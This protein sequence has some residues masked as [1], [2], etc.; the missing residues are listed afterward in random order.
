MNIFQQIEQMD[1][2]L[3]D[4]APML[5]NYKSELLKQGFTENQAF[6]LT[7]DYQTTLFNQGKP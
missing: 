7:R 2:L 4:V 1:S 3:R 5:Y 6:T